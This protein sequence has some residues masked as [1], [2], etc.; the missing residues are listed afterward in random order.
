MI[1][2]ITL[3]YDEDDFKKLQKEKL[4][5]GLSWENY[6]LNLVFGDK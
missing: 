4:K 1:K 5:S 2:T 6:I 3:N